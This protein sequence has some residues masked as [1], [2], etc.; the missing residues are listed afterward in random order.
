MFPSFA[1]I[2][3]ELQP[4]FHNPEWL[5][6]AIIYEIYPQSY[7]DTNGDGIG[8][9]PGIIAKL[10]YIQSLG[11]NAI[12]LNPCFESPFGDAGYDV[13]DFYKVAPRYGTNEDLKRLFDEARQRGIRVVLDL[14]AGHT[15][16]ECEWFKQSARHERNQYS[17]WYIWTDNL[18]SHFDPTERHH[19]IAGMSERVGAYL[20]NFFP[21]QPALNYGFANPDP[22]KPYQQPVDAPGPKAVRAE[23]CN[24]IKY[25]LDM[26]A[27]GFRVDMAASLVKDDPGSRATIALWREIRAWLDR[28]YPEAV[29][30]SEWGRPDRA[31]KAGF[32]IDFYLG[33]VGQGLTSLFRKKYGSLGFGA[34]GYSFFDTQGLGNIMEF[35][36]EYGMRYQATRKAGYICMFSGNHDVAPRLGFERS[37]DD[38]KLAFAFLLTMPGV[39]KIYY[40]D[41]VGMI[42]VQGLPSKEG[43]YWRTEART[44]MQWSQ[45]QNAGF[46]T[47][48]AEQLYLPVEPELDHRTVADQEQD[49]DS[50][51]NTVRELAQLRLAHPALCNRSEY[52]VVYAQPMRYP[53]AYLRQGDGERIV[54]VINP[55]DRAE[56]ISLPADALPDGAEAPETLWGVEGGLTRTPEGWQI[57]LPG[58][59]AGVYRI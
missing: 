43:S 22:D 12:W 11:A 18:F 36:E 59:S 32:H 26:G 48:G 25:W 14:V 2:T 50:L 52:E 45:A 1:P 58:V 24:I 54:V 40:G 6:K 55:A 13:A 23:L 8:D 9:L 56:E 47:A 44:P 29:L 3:E 51:L 34:G 57:T 20:P 33:F 39:P 27:D 42:G 7:Y 37:S 5:E 46:S 17:D 4:E 15:S 31:L 35:V 41:E 38:L 10:D 49:P 21:F 30:I 19:F 53:F 16:T 28:E